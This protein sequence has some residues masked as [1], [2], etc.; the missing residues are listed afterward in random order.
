MEMLEQLE[1]CVNG[2]LARLTEL[3]GE[4]AR[5]QAE[6]SSLTQTRSVLAAENQTLHAQLIK[7]ERLRSEVLQ[8]IDDLLRKIQ[9][10]DSVRHN[11]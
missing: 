3:G 7:E 6:I 2:L 9:E 5:L 10:H 8:R 1:T 4:N 11:L